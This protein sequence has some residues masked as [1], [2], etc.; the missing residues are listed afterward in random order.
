MTTPRPVS[1]QVFRARLAA[2]IPLWIKPVR[3]AISSAHLCR[4]VVILSQVTD[5][6]DGGR[7]PDLRIAAIFIILVR[8]K[9]RAHHIPAVFPVLI[10]PL[11]AH[12]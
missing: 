3:A 2:E 9:F 4:A 8:N 12:R 5:I 1:T 6:S 10:P 11:I 7:V